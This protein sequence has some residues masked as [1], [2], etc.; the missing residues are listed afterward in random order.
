[1]M[2]NKKDKHRSPCV[3]SVSFVCLFDAWCLMLPYL[4]FFICH[5]GRISCFAS[6]RCLSVSLFSLALD[7]PLFLIPSCF[8]W[9]FKEP[10]LNDR[11]KLGS[12]HLQKLSCH[13]WSTIVA[14]LCT[15]LFPWTFLFCNVVTLVPSWPKLL[16]KNSLKQLFFVIFCGLFLAFSSWMPGRNYCKLIPWNNYFCNILWS[17]SSFF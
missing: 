13:H 14:K 17:F 1:M 12:W 4:F 6:W 9:K 7:L 8:P 3:V 11:S 15:E 10:L 16:Q 5:F 2:N